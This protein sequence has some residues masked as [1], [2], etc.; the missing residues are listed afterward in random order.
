MAGIGGRAILCGLFVLLR[1]PWKCWQS[2]LRA[3]GV[4]VGTFE[5]ILTTEHADFDISISS[6]KSIKDKPLFLC[7]S[8]LMDSCRQSILGPILVFLMS[9][10]PL[11]NELPVLRESFFSLPPALLGTLQEL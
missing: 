7:V 5:M 8:L 4:H 3:E 2:R 6:G 1:V 9:F 10:L 11:G